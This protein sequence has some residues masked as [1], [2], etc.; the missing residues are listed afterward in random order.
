MSRIITEPLPPGENTIGA[1]KPGSLNYLG[2]EYPADLSVV[3]TLTLPAGATIALVQAQGG[4]VRWRGGSQTPTASTGMLLSDGQAMLYTSG[5]G[6][7]R[8]IAA[9]TGARLGVSYFK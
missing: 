6:G 8:F 3:T 2:D 5:L 1:M 4:S 7:L 9:T